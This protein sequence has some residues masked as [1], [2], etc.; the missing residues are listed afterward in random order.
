MT[1]AGLKDPSPPPHTYI[2]FSVA[3][4]FHLENLSKCIEWEF[5]Y[6]EEG[7]DPTY[8]FKSWFIPEHQKQQQQ[9]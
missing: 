9:K 5:F 2:L 8:Q 4:E 1:N 6:K 7:K 3:M